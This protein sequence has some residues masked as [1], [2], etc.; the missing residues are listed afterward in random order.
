M[1]RTPPSPAGAITFVPNPNPGS[2]E[3]DNYKVWEDVTRPYV[4]FDLKGDVGGVPFDGNIG[5]MADFAYQNSDGFSGNGGNTV[6]PVTGGA[7]YA[8]I[9]PSLNLIFK[10]TPED[11]IRLF[12]GRQEMRPTMYQMRAARDY[13]YNAA[14]ALSTV[15]S[16]W[17][18]T[19]GN[20]GIHPWLANSADLSL[21]ALLRARQRL[22]PR[23][24]SSRR[25]S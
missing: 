22:P 20:P 23:G 24:R 2:W 21:R 1:T 17:S 7:T 6:F 15:N 4:Q 14:N 16:P 3:G 9:L 10:P 8:D 19:S 12:V 13:G 25:S 11:F 5:V 18:G